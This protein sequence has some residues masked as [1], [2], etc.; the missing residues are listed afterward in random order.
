MLLKKNIQLGKVKIFS[1]VLFVLIFQPLSLLKSSE[2]INKG[3]VEIKIL[4]KVYSQNS[5][6]KLEIGKEKKYKN[7]V[8]KALKCQNSKFDD[9]PEVTAYLQVKDITIKNKD[10]VFVF[11]D[12]TFASSPTIKPFDH[13]IYDIWLSKCII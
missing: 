7:L 4:D 12:W 1:L 6:L 13:P 5:T 8:I 2:K 10:K 9:E 11:N 3:Y